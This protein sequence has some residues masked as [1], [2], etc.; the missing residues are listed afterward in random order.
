MKNST[1]LIIGGDAKTQ[2]RH[3]LEL[4]SHGY[5]VDCADSTKTAMEVY[6]AKPPDL[7][8]F[9]VDEHDGEAWDVYRRLADD[10]PLQQK[11]FALSGSQRLCSVFFGEVEILKPQCAHDLIVVVEGLIGSVRRTVSLTEGHFDDQQEEIEAI[12]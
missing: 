12:R 3:V 10:Y 2:K 6:L 8:L 11:A 7:V 9:A 4:E 5:W 1:I